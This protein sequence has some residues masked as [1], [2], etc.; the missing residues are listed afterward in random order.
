MTP[1]QK[2]GAVALRGR[3]APAGTSVNCWTALFF[4][5]GFSCYSGTFYPVSA[6]NPECPAAQLEPRI[7]FARPAKAQLLGVLIV[8]DV[9][10]A[11]EM[12]FLSY[13]RR[14]AQ[15]HRAATAWIMLHR[16]ATSHSSELIPLPPYMSSNVLTTYH[17]RQIA[18]FCE[19]VEIPGTGAHTRIGGPSEERSAP[20][21]DP[22][23]RN[24][25]HYSVL[26]GAL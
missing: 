20:E 6:Q 2:K 5:F 10:D 14:Q 15:I 9:P 3:R 19:S 26:L 12:S 17:T 4:L 1:A 8:P 16:T 18:F 21:R 7:V 22:D 11:R 13:V 24:A 25:M 23:A